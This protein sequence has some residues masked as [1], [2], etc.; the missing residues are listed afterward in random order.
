MKRIII[1]GAVVVLVIAAWTAAWF[2]GAGFI[3]EQ[4]KAL[5]K[6][7][8]VTEPKFTCGSLGV[9]GFPFGFDLTCTNAAVIYGDVTVTA[10]GLKASAEVYNPTF[11]LVFAQSPVSIADAF[12]GSQSRVDFESARASARLNGWRIGRVSV[13]V[14]KP[15]WNDT[16]LEDRLIAR[17]A[18]AE[19]HL[20]DLPADHDAKDGLAGLGQYAEVEGLSAPGFEINA[21]RATL[22]STVDKLPDDV[23]SY[24]DPNLL[25]RWQAAGGTFT[26]SGLSAVDGE[27]NF[28]ATGTLKLDGQ[29][30]LDGQV[31]LHSKGVVERIGPMIPEAYR[32]WIVGAQAADGSYSQT[33]NIAAGVVF[34][35]LIPAGMVPP[36]F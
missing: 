34:A 1:L 3:T 15:V 5:A 25:K 26:L 16:V 23:R 2:W 24:G 28:D 19:A 36:A 9:G 4:V 32:G 14:E 22:E 35:G 7:D 20:I 33:L 8:G 17:A 11:V 10:S 6:E 13:V 27:S 12:T 21:A 31:K 18:H 29:G 30:R